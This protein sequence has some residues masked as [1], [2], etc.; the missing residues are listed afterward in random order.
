MS[1]FTTCLSKRCC[2]ACSVNDDTIDTATVVPLA[3]AVN[4]CLNTTTCRKLRL[5]YASSNA[6]YTSVSTCALIIMLLTIARQ[7]AAR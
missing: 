4:D 5:T 2:S 7:Q 1:S 6:A 3:E